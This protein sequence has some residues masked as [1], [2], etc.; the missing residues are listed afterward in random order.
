MDVTLTKPSR[1]HY[2]ATEYGRGGS[3]SKEEIYP[4]LVIENV[5]RV[6]G[7]VEVTFEVSRFVASSYD[8]KTGESSPVWTDWQIFLRSI[9]TNTR[10]I[11]DKT[12][13]AI[14]E[15]GRPVILEWL[16]S[17]EYQT[18]RRRA[19]FHTLHRIITTQSLTDYNVRN[20]REEL[21]RHAPEL[22]PAD[23]AR[24]GR[25]LDA[26]EVAVAELETT[27]LA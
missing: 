6:A 21:A 9:D 7:P 17:E 25:A 3:T 2:V 10:G 23:A 27:P 11:G 12:R 15:A 18:S 16:A 24:I 22:E 13:T 5:P 1:S 20:A 8:E 14:K 19:L 26:L 4:T